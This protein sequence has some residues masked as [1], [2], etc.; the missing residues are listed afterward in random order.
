M[1]QHAADFAPGTDRDVWHDGGRFFNKGTSG[2]W[3]DGI[4]DED[5]SA[6]RE[7]LGKLLPANAARWLLDGNGAGVAIGRS[8]A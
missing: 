3:R 2:K 6:F 5:E 4:T 8:N 1:K 7:K